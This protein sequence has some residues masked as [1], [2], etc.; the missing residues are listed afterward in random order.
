MLFSS[1]VFLW[2]FLPAAVFLYYLAPGRNAKNIV[3]FAASLIFYGWGGPRYLLLVLLTALLC[4]AAGL[5][6]DA[7]GERT[8]LK[9]LSVGVFVLITL[10]ILGYFKYYNFFAATAGRLAGKELFPLRDIVLPLGISFYTFQAISYVVDV[11]RG[12]SP[13]Q[14]NLFHMALYLFLFP[15]ILSGPIIKYHQVAGQLTNRNETISMQFY[16]I[17]RFVYGLAKKVL[18]ANTFGQSVDYI[19][20]VPSGQMG[21]LTAW[22]AVILYTL[23]IYYDFS[24]YSDMAIGL[25]RIFGFYYEENFNYPYLSS[26]ITEFW[27]RWHIS[28]STWFRD[29]LYIPLG[30]NRKG[31]GRTCVNLFIV[32][33]ATGLWHGASM[34]FIIWGIYHGIFILSERLWLKKVL[35]RN[36][37]KFLNHLY[38][39]FVV[40][41]GWLLFRAPSMTYA[42]DLAKAM[43]RP[44]KGLWNAGLFANNKILF[45]AVL[46]I[47]LCGPVQAL[48]PRFRNHIFDE[49][50]VSY[51]DIAVMIVLLFLSTMVVVSSTYTAFI[52]FQF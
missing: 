46:G 1:L 36:P 4:Y 34:T 19:M 20:G 47:L 11:Y 32:F 12:K 28:L 15:Q 37:V 42:I 22:L 9:K 52:Y 44:S 29:Y 30:G 26:S 31:L 21:T 48:F 45:L 43:I 33:L 27:R 25:G 7:A 17:K 2:F 24:G 35:D 23:Q 41:F 14:K 13:A 50:N 49:E 3:L 16:G 51:G 8:A 18:L 38:A 6:L 39:M 40:V 5:C 10:G